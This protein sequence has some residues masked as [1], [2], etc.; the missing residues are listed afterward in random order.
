M[1]M[2]CFSQA[3]VPIEFRR[4]RIMLRTIR[5]AILIISTVSLIVAAVSVALAESGRPL[6]IMGSRYAYFVLEDW[7]RLYRTQHPGSNIDI[8]HSEPS[9]AFDALL[10]G[11]I[12]AA[13]VFGGVDDALKEDA[14]DRGLRFVEQIIGWGA[15]AIVANKNNPINELSVD[16]V[17]KI[18]SGEHVNWA[19]VGGKDQAI[20]V[21]TRDEAVSGTESFFIT[22][23]LRGFPFAPNTVRIFDYDV[24]RAV[25]R[26]E[27]SIADARFTEAVR[28]QK[29]GLIK[30]LAIKEKDDSLPV[31]PNEQTVRNRSYAL[32]GPL[33][34]YFD[35]E[36]PAELRK[37]FAEF[38]VNTGFGPFFTEAK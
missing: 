17:R 10:A 22:N 36:R 30:I 24:T 33:V 23:V 35:P 7:S 38:C 6:K 13:A 28:A 31:I 4:F 37:P 27:E 12:D 29:K 20:T 15:V 3:G 11:G 32:A 34:L 8:T 16:Q 1:A 26:A 19:Q 9:T 21:I 18:F 14:R 25:Y 2:C 5:K